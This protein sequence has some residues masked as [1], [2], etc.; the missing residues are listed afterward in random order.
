MPARSCRPS[1]RLNEI[2]VR[3]TGQTLAEIE[4]R[5]ERDTFMSA[6]QA[7]EFGIVD[8]VI[9]KRPAKPKAASQPRGRPMSERRTAL[10]FDLDGT[11]VDSVYQHVLAWHHALLESG[12]ELSIWRIH[13]RIGMSGGLFMRALLRETGRDLDLELRAA[14]AGAPCRRPTPDC[15]ATCGR[16]P[17]RWSCCAR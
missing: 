11:L 15:P 13:R 3:H 17:A 5:M 4:S 16:C 2:Y 9:D 6:E 8:E 7:K 1:A 12:I 14:A 10:V